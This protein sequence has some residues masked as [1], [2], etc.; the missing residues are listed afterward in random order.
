MPNEPRV[1]FVLGIAFGI[2]IGGAAGAVAGASVASWTGGLVGAYGGIVCGMC[3][4]AGLVGIMARDVDQEDRSEAILM[5]VFGVFA[6]AGAVTGYWLS[7]LGIPRFTPLFGFFLG[8]VLPGGIAAIVA[9]K[10]LGDR[11]EPAILLLLLL[12]PIG[13]GL[14]AWLGTAVGSPV[15]VAVGLIIGS[16]LFG[17]MAHSMNVS[18]LRGD[19]DPVN[20][21]H[22]D[23]PPW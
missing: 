22:G 11:A 13:A 10:I 21:H 12:S 18:I 9:A 3:V 2:A 15:L 5:L 20:R 17:A 7:T 4:I 6:T 23:Y 16:V 19:Y 1:S 8:L 14:G